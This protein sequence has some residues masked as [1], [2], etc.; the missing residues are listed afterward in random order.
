MGIV[1]VRARLSFKLQ[2]RCLWN[3][4]LRMNVDDS[5]CTQSSAFQNLVVL[6]RRLEPISTNYHLG[7]HVAYFAIDVFSLIS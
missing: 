7:F 6:C 2:M 4:H 3:V 5:I 1:P